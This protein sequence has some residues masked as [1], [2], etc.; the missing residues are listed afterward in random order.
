M[1]TVSFINTNG[2]IIITSNRDEHSERTNASEPLGIDFGQK[3]IFFPKDE[4]AGGSWIAAS[5]KGEIVVLLNGAFI[6]HVPKPIYK[7]SRGLVLIDVIKEES[8]NLFIKSIDLRGIEPFTI[9]IYYEDEL[10]EYR[11]DGEKIH[12]KSCNSKQNYIWSSCTLYSN[13]IIEHRKKWFEIYLDK[14]PILDESSMM[15]FHSNNNND[16]ENGFI[17]NRD[18]GMKT[19]SITQ[20]VLQNKELTFLHNDLLQNKNY[21][22]KIKIINSITA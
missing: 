3:K 22:K 18:T 7:K 12:E 5:N 9:I 14:T 6:K 19:F 17:I 15:L 2:K 20:I 4:K 13:E 1:C 21:F 8:P 16:D 10:N 11:W